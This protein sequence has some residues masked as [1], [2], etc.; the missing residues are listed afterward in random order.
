MTVHLLL[1]LAALAA[2]AAAHDFWIRPDSFA[3]APDSP[4]AVRCFVGEQG[5][6]GE[7]VARNDARL[8]RFELLGRGGRAAARPVVGQDGA[9]PAGAVRV[10]D[11]GAAWVV[12]ENTPARLELEAA[13]FEAYLREEGLEAILARRAAR[14]ESDRPSREVYARCAKALLRPGGVVRESDAAVVLAP[15]GLRLELLPEA[16]PETLAFGADGAELRVRLL[17]EGAPL[18]GALVKATLLAPHGPTGEPAAPAVALPFSAPAATGLHART[19][20]HGRVALRLAR[21]GEW[22]VTCVHMLAAE[23]E[24]AT[25]HDYESLWASLAFAAM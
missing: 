24:A 9:E 1:L 14:G 19:D 25:D 8:L 10:P 16:D 22:L 4:L 2:P 11:D 12:F 5:V 3:P 18:A 7:P 17:F 20:A 13:K 6:A 21:G 23:G 15:V